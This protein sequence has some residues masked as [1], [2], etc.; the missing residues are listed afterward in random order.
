MSTQTQ[1]EDL[2]KVVAELE[3]KCQELPDNI[4]AHHH[5][6]LVYRK[7]G[8]KADARRE[9]NRCLELDPQCVEALI[10]LS[11]MYFEDGDLD[12]A[13]AANQTVVNINAAQAQAH[14]NIGLIMQQR[15][16]VALAID[17]YTKATQNDP[18]MHMAWVNLA[19]AQIMAGNY[20]LAA[21][22][23]RE[24]IKLEPDFA[25]AHNNLAVALYYAKDYKEAKKALD[26][27]VELGYQADPRFVQALSQ[28][29]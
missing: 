25:M 15:G 7:A 12:K 6:A 14:N 22:A 29:L 2:G 8:R 11:A 18:K 1:Q 9:L 5:L 19:T 20:E 24:A 13:L 26:K 3:Q 16:E 10:N 23:A 21:K 4:I 28:E 17:A 27:A